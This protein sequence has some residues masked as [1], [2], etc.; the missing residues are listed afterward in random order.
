[1]EGVILGEKNEKNERTYS[2][3]TRVRSTQ[4]DCTYIVIFI[5]FL[6]QREEANGK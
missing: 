3:V 6:L 5:Y 1:M 2:R 4:V